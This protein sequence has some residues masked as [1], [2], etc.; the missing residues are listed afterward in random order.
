MSQD[1]LVLN[2]SYHAIHTLDWQKAMSLIFQDAAEVLDENFQSYNWKDWTELS[3]LMKENAQGFVNTAHMRIA[4]PEVIRLTK[5]DRL[6]KKEVKFTRSNIYEHYKFKCCYCGQKKKRDE[7]NLDHV[8]PRSRGGQT[9]WDNIVLSCITCNT[10]KDNKTPDE[11]GMKLLVQPSKPTWKGPKSV[12]IKSSFPIPV[13]WQ[14]LLDEKYWNT[15]L[16]NS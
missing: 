1:T 13:S 15:E 6:P 11:A 8:L 5:Y 7:L 9:T 2:K 3:Q 4:I 12:L 10:K 16:E 14:R